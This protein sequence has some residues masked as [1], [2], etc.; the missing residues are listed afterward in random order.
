MTESLK[1]T[2]IALESLKVKAG[3]I[4]SCS[5]PKSKYF[6]IRKRILE[7]TSFLP[8]GVVMGIR[9]YYI[10]HDMTE[11]KKCACGC[12]GFVIKPWKNYVASHGNGADEVKN[13]KKE[14]YLKRYGVKNPSQ[15]EEVKESK[16][17]TCQEHYGSDNHMQSPEYVEEYKL[18]LLKRYGVTNNYNRPEVLARR[19]EL[20]GDRVE[21]ITA[22][23]K[24]GHLKS[25]YES[26]FNE[27][28]KQLVTPCFKLD[29]YD[30]VHE[31]YE[32]KCN[33]CGDVFK[34]VLSRGKE[35]IPRCVKCFP[36][37]QTTSADE[38]ML[39][40]YIREI[41]KG[42]VKA[43]C[44]SVLS[45]NKELDIYIP[46][47]NISVE[48]NGL[49]YHG[50]LNG[51]KDKNYHLKKTEECEA[52]S[53]RLIHVFEDELRYRSKI[54]KARLRNILGLTKFR[55]AARECEVKEI[56]SEAKQ[57]F[58]F[59]Y[60]IQGGDT[61]SVRLGLF[62]KQ[63]LVAVMT[64]S[65]NRSALGRTN[66]PDEWELHRF[67]S[68]G[69]FNIMGGADKLFSHFVRNWKPARVRTYADRRWSQGGLYK[70]MGFKLDHISEPNYWY[71]DSSGK[72]VRHHRYTFRKDVLVKEGYDPILTEW[73]IMRMKGYD[74]IWDCGTLV[75]EWLP[76]VT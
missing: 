34:G 3:T 73:E 68:I 37:E 29:E 20:L 27:R 72:L 14:A 26:L 70:K 22:K 7:A 50:E 23:K 76:P 31:E 21:E 17:R 39:V 28:L 40:G 4:S 8:D 43:P 38:R 33:F 51:G 63:R 24:A 48:I 19:V 67:A 25:F 13:K 16:K 64:F 75:F 52:K 55:L 12:G 36:Y 66:V 71:V 69:S 74:R 60:H 32:F 35:R 62:H 6:D 41:Y 58:L 49:Y 2:L 53:I 46:N 10:M 11:Q 42:E 30:G 9:T 1:D 57:K 45:E 59:K 61:S 5:S 47:K 44:R 54:V 65:P 15:A 18:A 56:D